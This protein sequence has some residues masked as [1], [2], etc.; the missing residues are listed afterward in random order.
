[1]PQPPPPNSDPQP[2]DQPR[3]AFQ[4]SVVDVVSALEPGDLVSYAEVAREAGRPGAAQAVANVLRAVP[5][6][7]WWRVIPSSGRLYRT[8]APTQAP[9]LE[10]EGVF[11]DRDRRVREVR[12]R[13]TAS[14]VDIE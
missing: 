5:G 11:V 8:H 10:A 4:Q 9:L 3:T 12:S 1:M 7:P 13:G 2:S 14:C 6:L